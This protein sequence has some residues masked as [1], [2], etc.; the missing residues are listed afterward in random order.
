[1]ALQK[2][3]ETQQGFTANYWRIVSINLTAK[4]AADM[5]M[6]CLYKDKASRDAGKPPILS[7]S[8]TFPF[9]E[10]GETENEAIRPSPFTLE[11]LTEG[12]SFVLA[13]DWLKTIGEFSDAT[14]A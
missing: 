1:M 14:D 7:K 12:N 3:Y 10:N 6:L 4:N 9:T 11:H 13:Y 2:N 5:I 8:F